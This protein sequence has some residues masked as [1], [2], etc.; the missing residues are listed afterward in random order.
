MNEMQRTSS[1]VVLVS[2]AGLLVLSAC[3][4]MPALCGR[5]I[6]LGHPTMTAEE[7]SFGSDARV[8]SLSEGATGGVGGSASVRAK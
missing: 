3:Q 5:G 2:V 8:R 4:P 1:P 7:I 6:K